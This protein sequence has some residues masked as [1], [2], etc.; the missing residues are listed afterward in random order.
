MKG[1]KF[2]L[3]P[4]VAYFCA[5]VLGCAGRPPA[6]GP[7]A[8]NIAQFTLAQGAIAVPYRQLLV[9]SGGVQPYTWSITSGSLPAGLSVTMDGIISGNPSGDPTQYS[10]AGCLLSNT[11]T[12]F[13]ITCNFAVQVVDSQS[14]VHAVD[15]G[16]ESITINQ[17]LSLT[18]SSLPPATVNL[19]YNATFMAANGVPPYT[20]TLAG[21]TQLPDGLTLSTVASMNNM[22]N[23]AA[24][25]GMATTAGVY[26]FTVQATDSA[27]ETA[28]AN[29]TITV[30]GQL[31]G[32]YAI[33]F[34]G[35][36]TSQPSGSQAFYTVAQVV[37]SGQMNGTG[38][39]SGIL[40]QSGSSPTAAGGTMVTGTFN[41]PTQSNFGTITFTRADN[42]ESYQFDVALSGTS[43]DSTLIFV[44]TNSPPQKWGS[45][46][47][48]KQILTTLT[49]STTYTFG[50]FGNDTSGA[51]YAGA[52]AFGLNGLLAVTGGAEDTN[53]NGALSGE[54]FITGGSFSTPDSNTG[55]GTATL[56]V[57][58]NP[59]DYVYY[60]VSSNETIAVS[61]DS[62]APATL[63]DILQQQAAGVG[64][65]L[66]L[67]KS[68]DMCQGTLQLDGVSST[69][70]EVELG[71]AS[72]ASC[73]G[74]PCVGNFMRSDS[75][76]PYYVDQDIAGS[77]NPI[78]YASGTYSIDATCGTN[79]PNPCGRVTLNL[80]GPTNQPVWYLV[81]T[82]QAFVVG[83]DADVLKG[84]LQAQS[85]PS[86]GFSLPNLLGSYLGGTVTPTIPNITNEI[87]VAGTPPPGG[88]WSQ[89][90]QL[91]GPGGTQTGLSFM[92]PYALD[93]TYGAGFG[94]LAICAS[95]TTEYCTGNSAFM[96]DPDNPP[97]SIVY[98]TGGAS[99]GATGGKT[100]LA[101]FN[102]GV[103]QANGTAVL[104]HSP[105]LSSYGR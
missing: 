7:G 62:G 50:M 78:S 88:T 49:A 18:T 95:M 33:Y 55:R 19:G 101:S 37:A 74:S 4:V 58:S 89:G 31:Q 47:L 38:N 84:T 69:Q 91:S 45:G 66:V 103:P 21:G 94:R 53:D 34:N 5:I 60:I 71:V 44:D 30:V 72:F 23:P 14:P 12:Q 40:D 26:T 87:D 42:S 35:F 1:L 61:S 63:V 17:D 81:T 76:P 79:F 82:T 6:N 20:Y 97:Y 102:L 100:G 98:I 54:Q 104:D 24:I 22:A 25:T 75:L 52:G 10:S 70:P 93:P 86:G 9:A 56:M 48:K 51:R 16:A 15:T 99:V 77:F 41:I 65:G 46:L 8:L 11:P 80:Q 27:M 73:S 68:G 92:G 59:V 13:P 90:Y 43:S 83:S 64:G 67:C 36:D 2:V 32:P 57:G 29:F 96:F 28:T 39:I 85:P 105:R 3:L